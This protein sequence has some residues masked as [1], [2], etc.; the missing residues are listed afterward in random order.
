MTTPDDF[1][2]VNFTN[3]KIIQTIIT[4]I[5]FVMTLNEDLTP[6][7]HAHETAATLHRFRTKIASGD[8]DERLR[9]KIHERKAVTA[10]LE[11]LDRRVVELMDP[12]GQ[13]DL[14]RQID[15][16]LEDLDS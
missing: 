4:A 5:G 1:A 15:D 7:S 11:T 9:L 2:S 3:A 14:R 16:L 12:N 10:F 6:A 8:L 13:S